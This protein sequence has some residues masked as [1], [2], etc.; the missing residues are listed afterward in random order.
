MNIMERLNSDELP[1]DAQ[2]RLATYPTETHDLSTRWDISTCM[3]LA[4]VAFIKS[5]SDIPRKKLASCLS[6]RWQ[7]FGLGLGLGRFRTEAFDAGSCCLVGRHSFH[8]LLGW[9]QKLFSFRSTSQEALRGI[10]IPKLLGGCWMRMTQI[11]GR[12]Y[13]VYGNGFIW[14]GQNGLGY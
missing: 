6:C 13:V 5:K 12:V 9:I 8:H 2:P 14:H 7:S 1:V 4:M 11:C 10:H 3:L